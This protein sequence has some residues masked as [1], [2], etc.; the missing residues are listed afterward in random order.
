MISILKFKIINFLIDIKAYINF[1]YLCLKYFGDNNFKNPDILIFCNQ[2]SHWNNVVKVISLLKAKYKVSIICR[3]NTKSV[4]KTLLHLILIDKT[5]ARI[6]KFFRP[7]IFLSPAVGLSSNEIPSNSIN[8]NLIMSLAGLDNTYPK[9]AFYIYN[10]ICIASTFQFSDFKRYSY[11]DNVLKNKR[12]IL[13]GYPSLDSARSSISRKTSEKI[14]TILYAPTHVFDVNFSNASLE[15]D[16]YR[17]IDAI[18]KANYRIIFRPHPISLIENKKTIS[19]LFETFR[20]NPNFYID[21]NDSYINSFNT[22]DILISDLSGNAFTYA[23][24]TEKPVLLFN[25]KN[26]MLDDALNFSFKTFSNTEQL[27]DLIKSSPAINFKLLKKQIYN[28][29][30]SASYIANVVK[31]ILAG[32]TKDFEFYEL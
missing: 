6:T 15:S 17:I 8:I 23:L 22:S 7:K 2:Y 13:A 4:D 16:G 5:S 26:K 24:S 1:K 18:L 29:D 28:L 20:T 31:S 12:I 30:C 14:T 11:L 27:I 21:L 3:F 32:T 9:N 25:R 19:T 10:Y